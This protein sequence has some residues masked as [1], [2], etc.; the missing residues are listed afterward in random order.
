MRKR[1]IFARE[2]LSVCLNKE[3]EGVQ[4]WSCRLTKMLTSS[5]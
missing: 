4:F 5:K 1:R 3:T 2:E